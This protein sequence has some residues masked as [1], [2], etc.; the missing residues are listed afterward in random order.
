MKN[1]NIKESRKIY[2]QLAREGYS[3]SHLSEDEIF[4]LVRPTGKVLDVGS[5]YCIHSKYL[6]ERGIE[7][8]ALDISVTALR[9]QNLCRVCADAQYLPFRQDAFDALICVEVLEHLPNPNICLKEAHRVL[10]K[11]GMCTFT[12]PVFNMPLLI[13]LPFLRKLRAFKK[14]KQKNQTY[15]LH[16]FSDRQISEMIRGF[17]N[18]VKIKLFFHGFTFVSFL[19]PFQLGQKLDNLLSSYQG[20]FPIMKLFASGI[21]VIAQK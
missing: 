20:Q 16:V 12:T 7:V 2:D 4:S 9:K 17:F 6:N 11:G 18:I 8:I 5:G 1:F 10:K 21:A 19:R 3:V 13:I 14:V 15:H